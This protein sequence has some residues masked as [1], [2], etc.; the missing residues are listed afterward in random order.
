MSCGTYVGNWMMVKSKAG[1]DHALMSYE[2]EEPSSSS[3][4][5]TEK[6]YPPRGMII[7]SVVKLCFTSF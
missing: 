3:I 7:S 6:S 1:E 5:K 4:R 2:V